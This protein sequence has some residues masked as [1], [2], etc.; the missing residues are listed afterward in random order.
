M[1]NGVIDSLLEK[2]RSGQLSRREFIAAAGGI[3]GASAATSLLGPMGLQGVTAT[4]QAAGL[5]QAGVQRPEDWDAHA[6]VRLH[7]SSE[8]THPGRSPTCHRVPPTPGR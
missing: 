8:R 1:G 7:A 2:A 4:A 6:V 5:A 3:V